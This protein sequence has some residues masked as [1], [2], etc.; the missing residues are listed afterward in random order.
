MARIYIEDTEI[1]TNVREELVNTEIFI[2]KK[3]YT[4]KKTKNDIFTSDIYSYD[5]YSVLF[6]KEVLFK[7]TY[8]VVILFSD[9][10]QKGWR[11]LSLND[12]LE[13]TINRLDDKNFFVLGKNVIDDDIGQ[14]S[15]CQ[16]LASG[17]VNEIVINFNSLVQ[18]EMVGKDYIIV[19]IMENMEKIDGS[20]E[21]IYTVA[22]YRKDGKIEKVMLDTLNEEQLEFK[23][24]VDEN[25]AVNLFD[26]QEKILASHKLYEDEEYNKLIGYGDMAEVDE[27][28]NISQSENESDLDLQNESDDNL[29]TEE[30]ALKDENE[31]TN[32]LN[33]DALPRDD[34]NEDPIKKDVNNSFKFDIET[35]EDDDD[36]SS[37]DDDSE[38]EKNTFEDDGEFAVSN[39]EDDG[40]EISPNFSENENS[41]SDEADNA[42]EK[43]EVEK[44]AEILEN[45]NSFN[46]NENT[47]DNLDSSSQHEGFAHSTQSDSPSGEDENAKRTNGEIAT[48]KIEGEEDSFIAESAVDVDGKMLEEQG[49][50]TKAIESD[51]LEKNHNDFLSEPKKHLSSDEKKDEL[52]KFL[53]RLR[54]EKE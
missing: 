3:T 47:N 37:V 45:D 11:L 17:E 54:T 15:F 16:T 24:I 51:N 2:K 44:G 1:F 19:N 5:D 35:I 21:H 34:V 7:E 12:R 18:L 41:L 50:K 25:N 14:I 13:I 31:N 33:A 6:S 38:K 39:A 32:L 29:S 4:I 52:N 9:A 46:N 8:L 48:P 53:R 26:D 40:G 22:V 42:L 27:E 20:I 23:F 28:M 43:N 10:E 30:D 49:E 36:T